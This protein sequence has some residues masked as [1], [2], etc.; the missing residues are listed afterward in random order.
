[1]VVTHPLSF[2][3][4]RCHFFYFF[5]VLELWNLKNGLYNFEKKMHY[6]CNH[7]TDLENPYFNFLFRKFISICFR[8]YVLN[9]TKRESRYLFLFILF[10]Y[11]V[12]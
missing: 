11:F 7:F 6:V 9:G 2:D 10:Y 5:K 8:Y 1:M 4:R 3:N 12:Q